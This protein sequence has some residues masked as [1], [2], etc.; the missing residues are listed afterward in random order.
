VKPKKKDMTEND[1]E[2]YDNGLKV[3]GFDGPNALCNA[4]NYTKNNTPEVEFGTWHRASNIYWI[5]PKS[6]FPP[7]PSE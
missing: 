3:A 1:V 5:G 7:P 6:G 2:V 4:T